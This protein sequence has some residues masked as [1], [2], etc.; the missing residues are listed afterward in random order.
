E[1][2]EMRLRNRAGGAPSIGIVR[3][4]AGRAAT[5]RRWGAFAR[6]RHHA[7]GFEALPRRFAE[8]GLVSPSAR[9]LDPL[10]PPPARPVRPS[11]AD[12]RRDGAHQ[13]RVAAPL[14][15]RAAGTFA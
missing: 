9:R 10:L 4:T 2:P 13:G 11:P 7:P 15:P 1:L 5:R 3:P 8:R 14:R 12:G 6:I